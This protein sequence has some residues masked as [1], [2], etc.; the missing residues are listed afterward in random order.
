M[1]NAVQ[2]AIRSSVEHGVQ[3]PTPTGRAHFLV[4]RLDSRGV[5]LLFGPK[6]TS[7][8][9]SWDCLEGV[10]DY[11]KGRQ[12]VPIGANRDLAGNPNTLDWYL[13][14][15]VPRQTANYVAVL[16]SHAGVLEL[17]DGRPARV[18]LSAGWPDS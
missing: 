1:A 4:D 11:L 9:F 10:V 12:W 2:Q 16:L 17:D 8:F 7:T 6:R 18:R 13:K 5:T 3:L 15:H 14:Q